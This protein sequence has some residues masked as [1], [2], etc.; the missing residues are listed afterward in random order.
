MY[1]IRIE[2]IFSA[3]HAMLINGEPE[4]LHG[5]DWRV[6]VTLDSPTLDA[7]GMVCDFHEL[8]ASLDLVLAPFLNANLNETPPFDS[9]N[10]TAEN[11]AGH[12]AAK[13]QP[14]LP[15]SVVSITVAVTEAPGC[16]ACCRLERG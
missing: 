15:A 9:V 14:D 8:E 7:D 11:V 1:S 6:R 12:V 13:L 2:R 10:P 16:E 3:A 5:H 4:T